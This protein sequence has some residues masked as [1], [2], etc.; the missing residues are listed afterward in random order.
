MTQDHYSSDHLKLDKDAL[1][2][3]EYQR[4][5]SK[6]CCIVYRHLIDGNQTMVFLS[7]YVEILTGY[8]ASDFLFNRVRTYSSIIHPEDKETRQQRMMAALQNDECFSIEYRILHKNG[9]E[10]WV[11]QKGRK[12]FDPSK[13]QYFIEGMIVD[14]T[15]FK[16]E[17][18]TV[19]N[20]SQDAIFIITVNKDGS[21]TY[22][23]T[24]KTHQKET[25][26]TL[27]HI[28]GKTPQ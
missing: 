12:E 11:A 26:I 13:N 9:K 19:F 20:H 14:I 17:Y 4:V 22:L 6:L 16:E 15:D 2:G 21:F 25:G 1:T 28:R 10:I 27:E 23:R 5:I 3:E 18:E 24:N 7:D 8:P